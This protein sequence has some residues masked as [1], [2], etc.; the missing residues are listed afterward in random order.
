MPDLQDRRIL[1]VAECLIGGT[2]SY[3]QEILPAQIAAFGAGNVALLAPRDKLAMFPVVPGLVQFGYEQERRSVAAVARL[4]AATRRQ[5]Q[6]FGPQLLHLHSTVAG[7][8]GRVAVRGM[9]RLPKTLY[10]AHGWMIDPARRTRSD[11]MLTAMERGLSRVTDRI[12][13][14]SPH[15]TQFLLAKGFDPARMTMILSGIAEAPAAPPPVA[16]GGALR[17]LFIGRL[18][19]QKGFDLLFEAMRHVPPD[20]VHL[21][22]IGAALIQSSEPDRSN[23]AI[24]Y[25]GWQSRE[26]VAA[27]IAK[28]DAVVMPSRW[29]GMPLVGLEAMRAG[30][31]LIATGNGAFPHIVEEGRT[32]LLID[33]HDPRFLADIVSR[34]DVAA[35]HRM[36]AAA[37]IRFEATFRAER[38]NAELLAL[39]AQMTGDRDGVRG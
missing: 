18:D 31:A 34:F 5:V 35:L 26:V 4:I 11:A 24:D 13:N 15:E 6:D 16:Q 14:I 17:L 20:A 28:A 1:H 38:M 33:N 39:Y 12:V 9:R 30:R 25:R 22:V 21:T 10:C 27:E 3:L 32:G 7:V 2:A 8:A 29:E 19:H 36:G 37:R 23:P